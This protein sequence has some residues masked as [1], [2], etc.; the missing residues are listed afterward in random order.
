[1]IISWWRPWYVGNL[2]SPIIYSPQSD[3]LVP[4]HGPSHHGCAVVRLEHT[5]LGRYDPTAAKWSEGLNGRSNTLRSGF[6]LRKAV[7][8]G[9]VFSHCPEQVDLSEAR[10]DNIGHRD[11][12]LSHL[13]CRLVATVHVS[14]A[15]RLFLTLL[16]SSQPDI[17]LLEL[18][19]R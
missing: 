2:H 3:L 1:M 13:P 8:L 5:R 11:G 6:E 18:A 4:Y 9:L 17:E 7:H 19:C 16:T 10:V 14:V 12:G 15:P